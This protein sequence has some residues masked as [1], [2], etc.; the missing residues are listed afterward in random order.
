MPKRKAI[1]PPCKE[2][3][4]FS[5]SELVDPVKCNG[6]DELVA[7]VDIDDDWDGIESYGIIVY[8]NGKI[9]NRFDDGTAG[10]PKTLVELADS[11]ESLLHP[12]GEETS[13]WKDVMADGNGNFLC[14]TG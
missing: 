3:W 13:E 11:E 7:Y 12:D 14:F 1:E 8:R 10:V 2:R 6:H 5:R 9:S 4:A